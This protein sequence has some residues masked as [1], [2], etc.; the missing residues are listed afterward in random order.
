MVAGEEWV[1]YAVKLCPREEDNDVLL[2]S[3][4]RSRGLRLRGPLLVADWGRT[5][6][7]SGHRGNERYMGDFLAQSQ[8]N[9]K[10]PSPEL[11]YLTPRNRMI[12]I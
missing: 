8:K 11:A 4:A 1:R 9:P 10:S 6:G 7:N 2:P 12:V 5:V 3:L